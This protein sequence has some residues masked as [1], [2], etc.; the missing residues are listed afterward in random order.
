MSGKSSLRLILTEAGETTELRFASY[1]GSTGSTDYGLG[2]ITFN[3]DEVKSNRFM[4]FDIDGLKKMSFDNNQVVFSNGIV[5]FNNSI[6]LAPTTTALS[7]TENGVIIYDSVTGDFLGRKK[8]SWISLT[9]KISEGNTKV[10]AIDSNTDGHIILTTE[11]VERARIIANGRFGIGTPTPS[12]ELEVNGTA[13]ATSFLG[14]LTGDS[15]STDSISEK[16]T[17]SGVTIDG[18]LLKDSTLQL[19]TSGDNTVKN[20]AGNVAITLPNSSTEVQLAGDL[21]LGGNTIKASDGTTAITTTGA[22]VNIAGNLTVTGTQTTINSTNMTVNDYIIKL[23]QGSTET[24][25][26]DLGIIFT[27]G[28]NVT[29]NAAN[30][31]LLWDESNDIFSFVGANTEDGTTTGNVTIDSYS[32]VHMNSLVIGNGTNNTLFKSGSSSGTISLTFP[33]G[34]GTNGQYLKTDG[35]GNLSWNAINSISEADTK[36]ETIDTGSNG[37]VRVTV[38]SDEVIKFESNL[39]SI[40]GSIIPS[41]NNL[42]DIGSASNKIRDLYVS[43]NSLWVG[44]THKI[45]V[46]GGKIKLRKRKISSTYIP[47]TVKAAAKVAGAAGSGA[48]DEQVKT[49]ALN[50]I[51]SQFSLSLTDYSNVKLEHWE[52]YMKSLPNKSNSKLSDIFR[53][54]QDDDYEEDELETAS[55]KISSNNNNTGIEALDTGSDGHIKFSTNGTERMRIENNGRVGI[56][57]TNPSK[58]LQIIGVDGL[59]TGYTGHITNSIHFHEK[60]TWVNTNSGIKRLGEFLGNRSKLKGDSNANGTFGNSS[61]N[62]GDNNPIIVNSDKLKV[63]QILFMKHDRIIVLLQNGKLMAVGQNNSD[64]IFGIA[65]SHPNDEYSIL[66]ELTGYTSKVGSNKI[67]KI[68]SIDNMI[69]FALLDNGRILSSGSGGSTYNYILGRIKSASADDMVNFVNNFDGSNDDKFIVDIFQHRSYFICYGVSKSGNLY[70]WGLNQNGL[71]G[72]GSSSN[73]YPNLTPILT[74]VMRRGID[75]TDKYIDIMYSVSKSVLCLKQDGK[76]MIWGDDLNVNISTS[77]GQTNSNTPIQYNYSNSIKEWNNSSN[78][79]VNGTIDGTI[80]SFT[81]NGS[82]SNNYYFGIITSNNTLY[83]GGVIFSSL[84]PSA[85][86]SNINTSQ[87]YKA[88]IDKNIKYAILNNQNFYYVDINDK[89]YFIGEGSNGI[90]GSGTNYQASRDLNGFEVNLGSGI[91]IQTKSDEIN[92][93][94]QLSNTSMNISVESTISGVLIKDNKVRIGDSNNSTTLS[95]GATGGELNLTLPNTA[96]SSGQYLETDGSGNLSWS[97]ISLSG[98]NASNAVKV[99]ITPTNT[100]DE[101]DFITFVSS[102]SGGNQSLK[103]DSGLTYN[104]NTGVLTSVKFVG[105]GSSLTGI[106]AGSVDKIFKGNSNVSVVSTNGPVTITTNGTERMRIK[107]DGNIV[108]KVE[109]DI[110]QAF[111][112][113]NSGLNISTK[114]GIKRFGYHRQ[115]GGGDSATASGDVQFTNSVGTDGD[116]NLAISGTVN[117]DIEQIFSFSHIGNIDTTYILLKDGTVRGYSNDAS[118]LATSNYSANSLVICDK[119]N[120]QIPSNQKIVKIAV[121][122]IGIIIALLDNGKILGFGNNSAGQFG[123]SNTTNYYTNAVLLG[124]FDGSSDEK[125]AVDIDIYGDTCYVVSKDGSIWG[126][127]RSSKYRLT[128]LNNNNTFQKLQTA[129]GVVMTN[130]MRRGI[131]V[132]KNNRVIQALAYGIVVLTQSG[133]I[134]GAGIADYSKAMKW[135]IHPSQYRYLYKLLNSPSNCVNLLYTSHNVYLTNNDNSPTSSNEKSIIGVITSDKKLFMSGFNEYYNLG[136]GT[137]TNVQGLQTTPTLENVINGISGPM[138]STI[139]QLGDGTIKGWGQSQFGLLSIPSGS[140]SANITNASSAITFNLGSTT[141]NKSMVDKINISNSG[142]GIFQFNGNNESILKSGGN[143][144]LTLPSST[145]TNGQFLKTD[146]S[147]NL[148]FSDAI[149]VGLTNSTAPIDIT[150]GGFDFTTFELLLNGN[151]SNGSKDLSGNHNIVIGSGIVTNSSDQKKFTSGSFRV[152]DSSINSDNHAIYIDDQSTLNKVHFGT[153]NFFMETFFYLDKATFWGITNTGNICELFHLSYGGGNTTYKLFITRDGRVQLY[154]RS[155]DGTLPFF[156]SSGSIL[157]NPQAWNHIAFERYNNKLYVYFD[158]VKVLEQSLSVAQ[159]TL[160]PLTTNNKFYIITNPIGSYN[161]YLNQIRIMNSA[162]YNGTNFTPPTAPYLEKS[163]NLNT[164][165]RIGSSSSN[166][167]LENASYNANSVTLTLPVNTG[168]NGQLLKT[169]GTGNLYFDDDSIPSGGTNGQYLQTN[170]SGVLSWN[171]VSAGSVDKIFKGNS[172]VSVVSTNGPVTITTNGEERMRIKTDGNIVTKVEE[173]LLQAFG[174]LNSGLNISTKVGIKRFGFHRQNS[175]GDSATASG[176]VQ[177]T[178]S[179]GTDGDNNLAISGTVNLDIEQI[180]SFSNIYSTDTTYILLKDGTVRGYGNDASFL[181]TSNY[182][183]NSLVICDKLNGQI[184]SNQKIVKI[185]VSNIGIIIALL[186]NGKILGFGNNSAGQF[187]LSNT[188]NAYSNA[189]LLGHFD[190]SSDEKYAVDIDIYGDT[191]YVVSKDGSIWGCGRSSKYRLT[192]LNNNNTFQKLQTANGVVMTNVM[193]RGIDVSKNN[194]VIQALPYGIVVLTQSGEIFGSGM[195]NYSYAMKWDFHSTQSSYLSKLL[196]SPSNCVNLL[197]TTHNMYLTN[198]DSTP[199]S[200]NETSIIGVITSDKKLFMSG[201]NEYYNLGN[202]TTTNVQ[203]LQTTPTLE[204]VIN[205]ISGSLCI[206]YSSIRRW[207]IKRMG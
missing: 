9:D 94:L 6:Q 55:T 34:T 50:Y 29:T 26:K 52:S 97:T 144:S 48:T 125:Y 21:K 46:Q 84:Y 122:N 117:L 126:C 167:T 15:V 147:G 159:Q 77:I 145:G 161:I 40:S 152:T 202:G 25:V 16:T 2:N 124:H 155:S 197:Y 58:T 171:S 195:A 174:G 141:L 30:K 120:G 123:L 91:N 63:E 17:A 140:V 203:G 87:F 62:N 56:G 66:T 156:I 146:G 85:V 73:R 32:N 80:K 207:N 65:D 165:L 1:G 142:L 13:K 60:T 76:L 59:E 172:N 162:Q 27:R 57:I 14:N 151:E 187:G 177:F 79:F 133:E 153:G 44:D 204:N 111:G 137:T 88:N 90:D 104:P 81:K 86:S 110:L 149:A 194:R 100:A 89:L 200:S 83:F 22:N 186:D 36:V 105:D 185:A 20:S 168:S 49:H 160:Y 163:I 103:S 31:A 23:G 7:N 206:N 93:T 116:N 72:D 132:S 37:N 121:S 33:D 196:N 189:V 53:P 70:S 102:A 131:D 12:N 98:V 69:L 99:D 157:L 129:N 199:T 3:H 54:D 115:N 128:D 192:D 190:G 178:N 188:N 39:I 191:C 112:G 173:D 114:V 74:N 51:N 182:S 138:A 130:V 143:V 11:G 184:P 61:S 136:N 169:D 175:G 193:R 183:T 71:L 35:S 68:D 127:G 176:D 109:E 106:S 205:G 158:G 64:N 18:V 47:A 118:F 4:K 164:K 101:T 135:D 10:E 95:S 201:F 108:T 150:A 42:Y 43:D 180:F 107:S 119:L 179:V 45:A 198:N 78:S 148:S 82:L 181:A 96:G 166:V 75:F 41:T 28:N 8:N 67:I 92:T 154:W 139:V 113:L 134:F 38:D 19:G 5:I 24:P 170:G